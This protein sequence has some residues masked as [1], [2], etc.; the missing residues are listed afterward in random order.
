MSNN[1]WSEQKIDELLSQVPQI[2][3]TRSKDEVLKRLQQ[4]PRLA[5][6]SKNKKRKQ[7]IPSTVAVAAMVTLTIL[8]ASFLNNPQNEDKTMSE[9][10]VTDSSAKLEENADDTSNQMFSN[11]KES[12]NDSAGITSDEETSPTF[13]RQGAVL[14]SVYPVDAKE[15]TVFHIGMLSNDGIVVPFTVL[16]PSRTIANDLGNAEPTSLDLYNQYAGELVESALGF[17]EFHPFEGEFKEQQNQLIHKLPSTH[18]YDLSSATIN[19]YTE[20]IQETFYGYDQVVF[21][22]E[23]GS[24]AEFDQ[25]GP[26]KPRALTSGNTFTSF[27]LYRDEHGNQFLVPNMNEMHS[28]IQEAM[29]EMKTSQSDYLQS[30]IPEGINFEVSNEQGVNRIRF[31]QELNL[32]QMDPQAAS[33]LI[34]GILL[35]NGS[36][37]ND[38][39]FENIAPLTWNGFDFS[40]P[41]ASPV[42]ANKYVWE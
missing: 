38:V 6:D 3:D 42:G 22:N 34:E 19:A 5:A 31:T 18:D 39:Q 17:A 35:T 13:A 36:F 10:A 20:L 37:G 15:H 29:N 23:D 26:M 40:K 32:E 4:D 11:S 24:Q 9:M 41:V 8:V 1:K 14:T 2:H 12:A 30:V 21:Q 16:I 27:Y 28:D 25:V 7:W 33:H